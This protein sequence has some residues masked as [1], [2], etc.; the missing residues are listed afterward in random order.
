MDNSLRPA[1]RRIGDW[2]RVVADAEG[3]IDAVLSAADPALTRAAVQRLIAD[4]NVLIDDEPV[5]KSARV[6]PGTPIEYL[7]PEVEHVPTHTGLAL[8]VLYQD[9]DVVAIDKPA[10]LATHGAP[11]DQSPSVATWFVERYLQDASAFAVERPGIVHRLDKDTSGVLMLA[12]NPAAQAA[13]G[14]AF[15]H[16]ET[17]KTYIAITDGI[18]KQEHAIIDAAIGRHPGDRTRMAIV[19][20][21]RESRTEYTVI[22]TARDHALIEVHPETGR[23]HQIR[24]HLGA[25]GAHIRFDSVYGKAGPGRQMLHAWRLELPHPT[26][27]ARL[28]VTAPLPSD[29]QEELRALGLFDA[30]VQYLVSVAPSLTPVDPGEPGNP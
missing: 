22:A 19:G 15:E 25:I 6:L 9:A 1:E 30:A 13:L 28:D 8:P 2:Q 11:G 16:R 18:P 27:K 21:G 14:A 4:G 7:V 12:R 3:R 29:M 17:R 24:V 26:R 10:A 5:R 23:T 20:R